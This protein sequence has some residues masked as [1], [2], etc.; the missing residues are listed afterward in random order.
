MGEF[1]FGA[2]LGICL[3]VPYGKNYPAWQEYIQQ[4]VAIEL[5][6]GPS[7]RLP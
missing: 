4:E 1:V 2:A 3:Q 7:A 6:R 5:K